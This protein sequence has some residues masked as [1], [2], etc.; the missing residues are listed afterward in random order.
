MA[1]GVHVPTPTPAV[2]GSSESLPAAPVL[3]LGLGNEILSDDAVGLQVARELRRRFHAD[4]RIEVL[5]T[6]EMGLALLDFIVGRQ[7]VILV[8]AVQTT[9]LRP[10]E[11]HEAEGKQLEAF[12]SLAPHSLGVGEIMT[13][14]S[15]LGFRMPARVRVFAVEVED[16]FT[17]RIGLSPSVAAAVPQLVARVWEVAKAAVGACTSPEPRPQGAC[18]S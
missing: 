15:E 12:P 8:D 16:P 3:I 2:P 14:G 18:S 17:L 7:E 13:L 6:E 11:V 9:R 10:G 5:E 1:I 4:D